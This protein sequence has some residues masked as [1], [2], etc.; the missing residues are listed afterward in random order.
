MQV[1]CTQHYTC[2][3]MRSRA[4]ILFGRKIIT[5]VHSLPTKWGGGVGPT[6]NHDIIFCVGPIL[7]F[8]ELNNRVD[9]Q[10][11]HFDCATV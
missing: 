4:N 11:R 1:S 10:S 7:F 8:L 9:F 6:H 3:V 5:R 2:T